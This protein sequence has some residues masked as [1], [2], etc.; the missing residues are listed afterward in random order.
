MDQNYSL[1]PSPSSW[2]YIRDNY[3]NTP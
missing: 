2:P 3:L 1:D